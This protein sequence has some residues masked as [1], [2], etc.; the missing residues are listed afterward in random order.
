MAFVLFAFIGNPLKRLSFAHIHPYAFMKQMNRRSFIDFLGK[1]T[2]AA[3]FLPSFLQA[4]STG[5]KPALEASTLADVVAKPLNLQAIMPTASD[6]LEL[7][8]G[9]SSQI[10]ISWGDTL[11]DTDQF[12][13]NND[14]IQ[15]VPIEGKADEALLW[16]NH[17]YAHPMFVSG[18]YGT[19]EKT[20]EQ[21][22][23]E[24]YNVGGSILDIKRDADGNWNFV[25]HSP[26]NRRI[27]GS[28]EIPFNWPTEI[29]GSSVAIGTLANCSGGY[30]PWGTILTCEENYDDAYGETLYTNGLQSHRPSRPEYRWENFY[31]EPPEHYGWVVEVDPFT[32]D[33]QKHIALGRCAHECA[34]VQQLP[35]ERVVVY[36]GDDSTDEHLYKFIGSE[37]NSLKEGTLYVAQ[38]ESGTWIPVDFTLQPILQEH[39]ENQTEVLIRLR[40]AA[41]LLEATPLHRP[42]DIEVDP[43][44]G[45]VL[46]AL[47]N[48]AYKKDFMGQILQLTESNNQHDSLTFTSD[49]Y[50]AGGEETN[51]A[52]PDNMAFDPA[53]NLWITSDMSG[54]AMNHGIYAP[55]KNNGLFVVPRT[56]TQA[57]KPLQVASAPFDAELTGPCFSPDGKTLF[58]SVQHPGEQSESLDALSSHWPMGGNNLPKP[59]VVCITG[60][61]L[62]AITSGN[63]A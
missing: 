14:F 34:Y 8:D 55:F 24:R 54:S 23:L 10:L 2:V 4:C 9:L 48:N 31:A 1:G 44:T 7:A 41:K 47:T 3:A 36:S 5:P 57:G 25:P 53:G 17:E 30:T 61:T 18:F 45:K 6:V 28:T 15:F 59:S 56:G 27:T 58:L 50:L 39:F 33:A 11:S 49:T 26:F 40:E 60:S 16:V 42:E 13:F 19:M 38:M 12:G 32:G 29:K 20:Q 46:I 63:L 35:D 43:V 21:V 37:P 52:C 22:D 62:E 51:F